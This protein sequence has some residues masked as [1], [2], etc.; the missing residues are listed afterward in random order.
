MQLSA[1][2][3]PRVFTFYFSPS[4]RH[5]CFGSKADICGAK[6]HV[7][8][9]PRSGHEQCNKGCP[10][11][12]KSRHR[13]IAS[14]RGISRARYLFAVRPGHELQQCPRNRYR[15]GGYASPKLDIGLAASL[16]AKT[17]SP[18]RPKADIRPCE[19]N[20]RFG[21]TKF[22]KKRNPPKRARIYAVRTR[23]YLARLN[24]VS[25]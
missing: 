2:Q 21:P 25:M 9:T 13:M 10:L 6:R 14:E 15:R 23:A 12:A 16:R 20:V 3:R 18:V 4:V 11:C 7:R 17:A 24:A 5:V 22:S 8:F 19:T 1:R